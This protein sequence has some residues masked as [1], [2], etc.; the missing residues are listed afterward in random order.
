M[1]DRT[2]YSKSSRPETDLANEELLWRRLGQTAGIDKRG[3]HNGRR[4]V[5]V[6]VKSRN[7]NRFLHAPLH[8]EAFRRGD[9]LQLDDSE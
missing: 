7:G 3:Q 9:V 1:H 6:I 4:A 5:L 8:F 2:R